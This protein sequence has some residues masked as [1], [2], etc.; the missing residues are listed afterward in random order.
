[1]NQ[2]LNQLNSE[3]LK[4]ISIDKRIVFGE[5]L[6]D[7]PQIM[8]IGEAPGAQE[9]EQG[10]P[11]VG[12]AGKNL[13]ELLDT[14]GI[15]RS[16]IFVSNLVK[17]RPSKISKAGRTVN[18]PPDRKEINLFTPWL[19]KEINIVKPKLL[20]TLGNTSLKAIAGKDSIIGSMHGQLT[21]VAITDDNDGTN[22]EFNLFP[23]Y[24]P[25]AII[26]NR[27]LTAVY[28]ED[29]QKLASIIL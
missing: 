21:Q 27:S 8:L 9:E 2:T 22:K 5:G 28:H 17:I 26:Y 14:I 7:C 18:R 1:M 4:Q 24:H 23:M 29:L 20:V 19:F 6:S 3:M 15:Q 11:F 12:K 25:A 10:K 16:D 13:T